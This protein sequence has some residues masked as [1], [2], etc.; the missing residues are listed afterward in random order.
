MISRQVRIDQSTCI[1]R[2]TC[3]STRVPGKTTLI[4]EQSFETFSISWHTFESVLKVNRSFFRVSAEC[5]RAVG[6]QPNITAS[7][8]IAV[9]SCCCRTS[10]DLA[11]AGDSPVAMAGAVVVVVV[12]AEFVCASAGQRFSLVRSQTGA[13][14]TCAEMRRHFACNVTR[15]HDVQ[16]T[17]SHVGH[18]GGQPSA[19]WSYFGVCRLCNKK[20]CLS[21]RV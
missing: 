7:R 10:R 8:C 4:G 17:S 15:T 1:D 20:R 19:L 9:L 5:R 13:A 21:L 14:K 12:V 16:H 2:H 3:W 18:L 6:R 11:D